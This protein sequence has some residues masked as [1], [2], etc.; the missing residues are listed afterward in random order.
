[1]ITIKLVEYAGTFAENKDVA[2][3]LR[4]SMVLPALKNTEEV[5]I[6]FSGVNPAASRSIW[7]S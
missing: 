1:M 7:Y 5:T 2:A 6:D 4:E 3:K